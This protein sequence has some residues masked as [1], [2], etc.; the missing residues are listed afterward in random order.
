MDETGFS[1]AN[2]LQSQR[3][4]APRHKKGDYPSLLDAS[5]SYKEHWTC[6]VA[7]SAGGQHIPPVWIAQHDGELTLPMMERILHGASPSTIVWSSRMYFLSI[8]S[9][10]LSIC[11]SICLSVCLYCVLVVSEWL[12]QQGAVGPVAHLLLELGL[13]A[14]LHP[15]PRAAVLRRPLHALPARAADVVHGGGH[16]H[17][18]PAAQL[19][20]TRSGQR[21][22]L[23]HHGQ[24]VLCSCA[25]CLHLALHLAVF[26]GW[27]WC[28]QRRAAE[29]RAQ[30]ISV[31]I[32]RSN[33][34]ECALLLLL[35]L[36][37]RADVMV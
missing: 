32:N 36:L 26:L 2:P 37:P 18:L 17:H 25:L 20:R 14:A 22:H 30:L 7:V 33:F 31:E 29:L 21:S 23:L 28:V 10:C 8:L 16:P 6:V 27:L 11:L 24:G 4:V 1:G 3:V 5:K 9:V 19:H 13:A 34:L 12:D 35:L 15:Q